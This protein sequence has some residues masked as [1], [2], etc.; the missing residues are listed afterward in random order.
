MKKPFKI[1]GIVFLSL[2]VLMIGVVSL[3]KILGLPTTAPEIIV[4]QVDL[5]SIKD[6]SYNGQCDAGLV[7][8]TVEVKVANHKITDITILKHQKGLGKKAEKV[9]D[10]ILEQQSLDVDVISGATISSNAIRKAV[11][12]ALVSGN[13]I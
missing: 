7:K 1:I 12:N 5:N 3:V 11:E 8:V 10:R 2:I 13:D 9:V 6:G 4:G